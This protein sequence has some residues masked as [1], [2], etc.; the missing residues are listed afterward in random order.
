MPRP[1]MKKQRRAEIF[2]AYEA[3]I[4]RF[5]VEGATLDRIAEEAGLARALIRHNVGNKEKLLADFIDRFFEN[6]DISQR[7]MMEALPAE[8]A[9]EHLLDML[10]DPAY[11]D[12]KLVLVT[13]ALLAAAGNDPKLA[14]RMIAWTNGFVLNVRAV[15][16]HDHPKASGTSLDAA[17]AG[18]SGLYF[19]IDSFAML[20]DME[21]LR[22]HTKKAAKLLMEALKQN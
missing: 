22:S 19:N 8:N 21:P 7:E 13:E 10:F 5:G 1:N 15:L 9:S 16:Q 18:I 6:S 2:A 11:S 17:S 4:A 3:C 20:G 14:A 12:Q